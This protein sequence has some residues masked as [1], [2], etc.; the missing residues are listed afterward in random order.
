MVLAEDRCRLCES[1]R[2][3][4][5]GQL[6]NYEF[7]EL[8]EAW[9]QSLDR[10]VEAIASFGWGLYSS[11]LVLLCDFLFPFWSV[12]SASWFGPPRRKLAGG[13]VPVIDACLLATPQRAIDD[14]G[15]L[16]HARLRHPQ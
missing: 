10:G 11:G 8:Y 3:L 12:R 16:L 4:I 5:D 6:T 15:N 2:L 9:E 13:L 7:D 1:L 14:V